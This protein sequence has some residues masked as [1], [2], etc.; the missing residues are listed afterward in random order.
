M[1]QACGPCNRGNTPFT[2]LDPTT[3]TEVQTRLFGACSPVGQGARKRRRTCS[4]SCSSPAPSGWPR[5]WCVHQLP[6]WGTQKLDVSLGRRND[7][8]AIRRYVEQEE[9]AQ[10]FFLHLL[11]IPGDGFPGDV[12]IQPQVGGPGPGRGRRRTEVRMEADRYIAGRPLTVGR[13]LEGT[14]RG[15]GGQ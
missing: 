13:P 5:T 2:C 10:A 6:P 7:L 9:A 11:E 8:L 15:S 1:S 4:G 12:G 14:R 3:S